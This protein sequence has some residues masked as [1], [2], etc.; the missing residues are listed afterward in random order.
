MVEVEWF[1]PDQNLFFSGITGNA[2]IISGFK[3]GENRIILSYN[4][5]S[6]EAFTMDTITVFVEGVPVAADDY[7]TVEFNK[8]EEL[9]IIDNDELPQLYDFEILT[10]PDFG[11][12]KSN[13]NKISYEPDIM[14]VRDVSFTYRVC[15]RNCPDFCDVATVFIYINQDIE[16]LPPSIITPNQDGINDIFFIPCLSTGN[17]PRNKIFI[18]NE[19][20]NEVFSKTPY[21]N[22]WQGE[23]NGGPLPAGTYFY[24]LEL[25][26][27]SEPI[28]GFL[29]IQR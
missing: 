4:Y 9:N 22:D 10:N 11:T 13:G 17:F 2:A 6:C 19:W 25:D 8:S 15:S 29:I 14:N 23:Y 28:K 21:E 16:C 7:F 27:D 5:R 12:V 26:D 1:S 24:V 20:G 18:F 3:P